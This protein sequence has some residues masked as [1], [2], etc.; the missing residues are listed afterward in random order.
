M[1]GNYK[2]FIIVLFIPEI[3]KYIQIE[4]LIISIMGLKVVLTGRVL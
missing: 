4:D 3:V 2:N 1:K